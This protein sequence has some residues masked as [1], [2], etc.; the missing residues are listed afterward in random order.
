MVVM[1]GGGNSGSNTGW[2]QIV[3]AP[4]GGTFSGTLAGVSAGGWYQLEV[5]S[6]SGGVP[7]DTTVVGRIG[8]GDIYITCGQSNAANYGSPVGTTTDDRVSAWNFSGGAWTKAADPMPGAG[9]SGGSVWPRL[10]DL[11]AA[12]DNVPIAFAC[13]AV[14]STSVSQ[15][16]PPGG[17]Y[18]Q[19]KTAVQAFPVNG[20]RAAL[21]H[22]GESDSLAS[23]PPATY[24]SRIQSIIAQSRADAGW[25]VPWYL[26]EAGFH[27]S[28][29]LAQEEPVVAG[30]L[31]AIFA[32]ARVFPGPVT[33]DFH[34]EGKLNGNVH[35]N[36]AG[37]AAH[38]EQWAEVLGG[39]P[40]LAPKNGDFESNTALADGG[41]AAIDTAALTSPSVIGWRALANSGEAV[42]DGSCGYYNPD[43]SFYPG[44]SDSSGGVV[45]N[46]SGRHVAFLSGSAAGAHFLQTRRAMLAAGH[47]YTLT[48]ALGVRGNANTFGGAQLE[49]L[50][51]GVV[52]ASRNVTR[53]D[54]D[55]LH[56]G[57]ASGTFTDISLTL[58]TGTA[59]LANQP[60]AVRIRKTAGVG[61]YLDFDNVRLVA[62]V[63]PFAA[64]QVDHWGGIT[65]P[66][67]AWNADP[68]RDFLANVFEYH[69]GLDPLAPQSTRSF[70]S[71]LNHDGKDWA[72]YDVPLDP[73]VAHAGLEMEYSFDLYTWSPA[74]TNPENTV[75]ARKVA[76]SWSLEVSTSN[77]PR[78]FFRLVGARPE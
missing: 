32:D 67:A 26:A 77:H 13:V 74:A 4:A 33:D 47:S 38:A 68:D 60:L 57:N 36:A 12:R 23:T 62:V 66:A 72:R 55:A 15:W 20:F 51:N 30:Q 42:A 18:P 19:L 43:D 71:A 2:T 69:L 1:A 58:S 6:V 78:S 28:S 29:N 75:V 49:L 63:T 64:W 59:A 41:I 34:L 24:Q 53:A 16:V 10:G 56:S 39:V 44:A 37:L 22:Q 35:F 3:N 27:P 9:G 17:Y 54:L 61:T 11:L 8:I 52:L 50:G 48:A 76:T 21:W 73:T 45:P 25:T 70:L 46:M 40:P 14:G 5:R 7:G 65:Q 31:R